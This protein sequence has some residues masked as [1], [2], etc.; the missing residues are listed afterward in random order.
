MFQL[1]RDRAGVSTNLHLV[2]EPHIRALAFDRESRNTG[3]YPLQHIQYAS[4]T[5]RA[6]SA[7]IRFAR[8]VDLLA[9]SDDSS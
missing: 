6:Q 8:C 7:G 4:A 9:L 2:T 1:L 5:E 3:P